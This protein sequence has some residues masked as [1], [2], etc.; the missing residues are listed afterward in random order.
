MTKASSA[1]SSIRNPPRKVARTSVINIS[2]NESSP[3]RESSNN[4]ITTPPTTPLVSPLSSPVT[5]TIVAPLLAPQPNTPTTLAPRELVFTT[6][7]TSP[8]PYLNTLEDLPPRCTNPPPLH[9]LEQ[10]VS[11]PLPLTDHMEVEP[12]F[13]PTNLTRRNTRL[14][15]FPEPN[16]TRAQIIEKLNDL[17]DISN[18]I[19][20]A[21]QNAQNVSA[22]PITTT[23][24]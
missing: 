15:A 16:L 11:Q 13:P 21:L 24:S 18:T 5:T 4:Y 14:N 3:L 6:S 20:M 2:S 10:I 17:Q 19:D 7:P 22:I 12:F 9:T 8:H 1:S 23:T